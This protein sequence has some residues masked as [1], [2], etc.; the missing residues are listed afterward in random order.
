[1]QHIRLC[2]K[3]KFKKKG[4]TKNASFSGPVVLMQEGLFL[5]AKS[6]T[7][8]SQG[9][10][11]A[12]FGLIGA[13]IASW[14]SSLDKINFPYPV[15]AYNDLPEQLRNVEGFGKL[16]EKH[17]IVI[18]KREQILGYTSSFFKGFKLICTGE[19][20]VLLGSKRKLISSFVEYGYTEY[21][22]ES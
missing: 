9:A 15:V 8:E 19:E 21:K 12:L 1:M 6:V 5:V 16:T 20:I 17:K 18:V 4:S 14:F 2:K 11:M 10:A 13:L 7:T 3:F 22:P